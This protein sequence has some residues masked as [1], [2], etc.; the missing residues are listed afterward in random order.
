[1]LIRLLPTEGNNPRSGVPV[2]CARRRPCRRMPLVSPLFL[3]PARR[4]PRLRPADSVA[5][6]AV[7]SGSFGGCVVRFLGGLGVVVLRG[8]LGVVALRGGRLSLR[9]GTGNLERR[10]FDPLVVDLAA[11]ENRIRGGR[12]RTT[13][14]RATRRRCRARRIRCPR[15]RSWCRLPLPIGMF[16]FMAS[17]IGDTLA[18]NVDHEEHVGQLG[19]VLDALEV[20]EELELRAP[21]LDA[22][23][24]GQ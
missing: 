14:W 22:L 24:L 17:R 19:H 9:G 2:C 3:Q 10:V 4:N 7:S 13:G 1:M 16:K 15:D 11:L 20:A 18:P 8:G 12:L 21:Q 6:A 5:A 23:L